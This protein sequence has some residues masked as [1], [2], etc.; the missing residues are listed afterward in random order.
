[1]RI[2]ILGTG[3]VGTELATALIAVG[4]DVTFGSRAPETKTD[5]VAPVANHT[6]AVSSADVVINAGPGTASI[7]LLQSIGA[8]T[9]G[10]RVLLDV[11]NATNPDLSLAYP[12]DSVARRIQEAFPEL[13]VVKSLNTLNTSV[14]TNPSVL[15]TAT[16][17]FLSGNDSEAKSIVSSLLSDLGWAAD[18]QL[19]LGDISTARAPEHYFLLFF[20]TFGALKS[21]VFN[22]AVVR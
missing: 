18:N 12:N 1:M 13:R 19:D 11:S 22:I 21:P 7:D 14:M 9:L 10:N 20:A 6:D 8:E 3:T 16:T 4:Y 2:A 15:P 5:A 17:V